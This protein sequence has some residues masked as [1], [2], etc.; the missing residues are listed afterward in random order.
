M[1]VWSV[2]LC[3]V[4]SS[5]ACCSARYKGEAE[6]KRLVVEMRETKERKWGIDLEHYIKDA[7][8]GAVRDYKLK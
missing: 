7:L 1:S 8:R 3:G 6:R 2:G 5:W 4:Y